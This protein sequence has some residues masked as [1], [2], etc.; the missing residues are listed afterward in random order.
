MILLFGLENRIATRFKPFLRVEEKK[1]KMSK[2]QRKSKYIGQMKQTQQIE[3]FSPEWLAQHAKRVMDY[4][5]PLVRSEN[6]SPTQGMILTFMVMNSNIIGKKAYVN[7]HETYEGI[8][9]ILEFW[10]M[11]LFKPSSSYPHT[12]EQI[13]ADLEEEEENEEQPLSP[14]ERDSYWSIGSALWKLL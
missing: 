14:E 2:K 4:V 11:D 1:R 6:L 5:A 13:L 8:C 12:L 7:A 10:K 3:E 9:M